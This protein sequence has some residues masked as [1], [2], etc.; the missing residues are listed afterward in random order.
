VGSSSGIGSAY[1]RQHS[2]CQY[3]IDRLDRPSC[4]DVNGATETQ[5][6]PRPRVDVVRR[7]IGAA[8]PQRCSSASSS[9]APAHAQQPATSQRSGCRTPATPTARI[10]RR[11]SFV[12]SPTSIIR[13]SWHAQPLGLSRS[14]SRTGPARLRSGSNP[15]LP[16]KGRRSLY[17]SGGKGHLGPK[18]ISAALR[19]LPRDRTL[20]CLLF[21]TTPD[22]SR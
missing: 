16:K 18:A 3:A 13:A 15:S 14:E 4:Q 2:M 19:R 11:F 21:R 22:I 7:Y 20:P 5:A 17:K 9:P 12:P 10:A 1:L 6:A 8:L